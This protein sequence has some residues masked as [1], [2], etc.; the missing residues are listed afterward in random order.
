MHLNEEQV[1]RL[2]H[3][4]L[5]WTDVSP[6]REHITQCADCRD[7]L[8]IARREEDEVG[9]LLHHLDHRVAPVAAATL[10]ARGRS[11]NWTWINR[12]AVVLLMVSVAGV[13]WAAPG[14]PLPALVG[15]AIQWIAGSRKSVASRVPTAPPVPVGGVA[16]AP[17][18]RL[19]ILFTSVEPGSAARVSLTDTQD[20]V[21]RAPVGAAAFTSNDDRLVIENTGS[22]ATF[23]I[24]IPR[25]AARVEIRVDGKR[26]YLK[27]GPRVTATPSAQTGAEYL[28][29]LVRP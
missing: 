28:I 22:P 27:D 23:E 1:Q 21:V 8:T 17:G 7:R 20:V 12:A 5:A 9:E 25:T 2:L 6:V 29:P 13:A 19:S 11:R 4:E 10:I 14:S 3:G 15:K 26:V 24:E 16:V 18:S